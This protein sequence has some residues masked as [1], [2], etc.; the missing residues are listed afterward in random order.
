MSGEH[1][2][3][4]RISK[5]QSVAAAIA[6]SCRSWTP[7]VSL[8][9]LLRAIFYADVSIR[10]HITYHSWNDLLKI[11]NNDFLLTILKNWSHHLP[12]W[13]HPVEFLWRGDPGASAACSVFLILDRSDKTHVSEKNAYSNV[14]FVRT[15]LVVL[16][17][18]WRRIR[19]IIDIHLFLSM[20]YKFDYKKLVILNYQFRVLH[21]WVNNLMNNI[22]LKSCF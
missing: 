19:D 20:N 7:W 4:G 17:V 11:V 15:M 21:K 13:W 3:W 9:L 8:L 10:L 12:C 14:T 16:H 5:P 6:L 1:G 22:K 18:V 2:G